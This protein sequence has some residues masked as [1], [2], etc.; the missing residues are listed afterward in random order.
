MLICVRTHVVLKALQSKKLL[1]GK[2]VDF[3]FVPASQ[4][5]LLIDALLL[6]LI[7][8]NPEGLVWAGDTAQ[9]ISAGSSFRFDDLKAFMYR[10]EENQAPYFTGG[11]AI[12][13][14]SSFQLTV[15][16]RSH[17]GIVNCADSVIEL[18]CRFWP[19]SIDI[20]QR[21]CGIVQG[22]K[23]VF[24]TGWGMDSIRRLLIGTSY[25]FLYAMMKLE[26]SFVGR[27]EIY[28]LCRDGYISL[29][30]STHDKFLYRTLQ[31]CKGLEF[32]DVFLYN[33][34]EDSKMNSARW[35]L[36]LAAIDG[37]ADGNGISRVQAPCF[38]RDAARY[39]G[40]CSELKFLYVGVTRAQK[41][42]WIV[43]KS[44]QSEP[45]RLFWTTRSLVQA[46][47]PN[48]NVPNFANPAS[49]DDE[50]AEHGHDM[51]RHK[52]YEQ[53]MYCF[54]QAKMQREVKIAEAHYSR[55]LAWATVGTTPPSQQQKAFSEAADAFVQ[56]AGEAR[57]KERLQYYYNAAECYVH[58]AENCK[59]A[60]AYV[61]AEEYDLAA[62]HYRK[63]GI[64]DK[65]VDIIQAHAD[66]MSRE[67]ADDL[68]AVCRLYYCSKDDVKPPSSLFSSFEEELEFLETY[69]L[70]V[71]QSVLLESHGKFVEAAELHLNE[72]RPI[73][74]IK[75]LL[76]VTSDA[77]AIQRSANILLT[78]L[79]QHFSFWVRPSS[80]VD[81]T[82]REL[83]M[84]S[85]L[86]PM[87]SLSLKTHDEITMFQAA[88]ESDMGTLEKLA[89]SFLEQ[90][91]H[92]ACVWCLDHVYSR[93]A[94]RHLPTLEGVALFLRKFYSYA[95]ILYTIASHNNPVGECNIRKLFGITQVTDD[96]YVVQL[97]SFVSTA[98]NGIDVT[99]DSAPLDMLSCTHSNLTQKL[100]DRV[101]TYLRSQVNA[102]TRLCEKSKVFSQC[103]SYIVN[104]F[105]KYVS[106]RQAH[107]PISSLDAAQYNERVGI[108]LQQMRILQLVYSA[109]PGMRGW[110][111][112]D[113]LQY[114]S[115]ANCIRRYRP[116]EL[117]RQHGHYV[118]ED[119]L[120][121][122]K[123]STP[124]SISAGV[125][126]FQSTEAT[127]AS[128][129][130]ALHNAI[131]P[132]SWLVSS[133]KFI[134]LKDV[135]AIG[136]FLDDVQVLLQ[137]LQSESV[138][139]ALWLMHTNVTYIHRN[140]FISRICR[141]LC[142]FAYNCSLDWFGVKDKI[143]RILV[144]LR[145][146][147]PNWMTPGI[148]RRY[149]EVALEDYLQV[150]LSYEKTYTTG[151]LVY[152]VHKQQK[153]QVTDPTT[154]IKQLEYDR[155]EDIPALLGSHLDAAC[156]P[157][158]IE[159]PA[160][161]PRREDAQKHIQL[162]PKTLQPQNQHQELDHNVPDT[163]RRVFSVNP[164]Q[165]EASAAC[166]IQNAYRRYHRESV[167]RSKRTTLEA[168]RSAIFEECLKHARGSNLKP[169]HYRLLYLGP[170]V[171]LLL[172]LN[173]GIA[174]VDNMKAKT[175]I[176]RLLISE[177]HGRLEEL[178]RRRSELS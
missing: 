4:D 105:C 62:K 163:G 88:E 124:T 127:L 165:E 136:S 69:E 114:T 174:I 97:G 24:F 59:A 75:L 22:P 128:G 112:R 64:F 115:R 94:Q 86:L 98:I 31:K 19:N 68:L 140:V 63:A 2:E 156:S 92:Y 44:E 23:P 3:L 153:H 87:N 17:G 74:A 37:A 169:G 125:L 135:T 82:P 13:Q 131:L 47:T 71:A 138:S 76:R 5:N 99:C 95:H 144:G 150:V 89:A 7:C 70:D 96:T 53:A 14:P 149:T 54:E 133:N 141:I 134:A 61:C 160:F 118:V 11:R 108:H 45:M 80:F 67:C 15:N 107:V 48:T 78:C 103:L 126:Y 30:G 121:F 46:Y 157:L 129:A 6:R 50:W 175:K 170:L 168:E 173:R 60:D 28:G 147:D 33:F 90:G 43:D 91:N 36:V 104:G 1:K 9:T 81:D 27:L 26:K 38:E 102:E 49:K 16:Y 171:H 83:L 110:S 57:G 85:H 158:R 119:L 164:T 55:D 32:S 154:F 178:G 39:A 116:T 167:R 155:P 100:K 20:L 42:L 66:K 21:E 72:N 139:E 172:A 10:I 73:E 161:V 93:L 162:G 176:P 117:L 159:A 113:A 52:Q 34:F 148:Y 41:K 106:C 56:C 145:S 152:L 132:R 40:I 166:M 79:W 25:A 77:C 18:I 123:G 142:L 51:F 58:A 12:S 101:R 111:R 146:N 122:V 109:F 8:R 151:N 65:T 177:G 143:S 137:W 84:L 120:A 29:T 130:D 35:R